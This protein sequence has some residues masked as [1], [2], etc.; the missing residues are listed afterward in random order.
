M[1][2]EGSVEQLHAT[3]TLKLAGGYAQEVVVHSDCVLA[4]PEALSWEEAGAFC[5]VFLTVFLNVFELGNFGSG[6]SVVVHGGGSGIGTAAIRMVKAAGG[7]ILVTAG[8]AEKCR[9]CLELGADRAVNYREEDF[10]EAALALSEGGGVEVV[11]DSIGAAYLE[12]NL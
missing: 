10:L 6:Q 1:G 8:S 7:R 9:S 4:V 3:T 11:L 5:E 12:R 2:E